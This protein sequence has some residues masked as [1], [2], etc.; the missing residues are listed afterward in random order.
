MPPE[1]NQTIRQAIISA[2]EQKSATAK[3]LSHYIKVSE[4]EIYGHL[5]HIRK[6]KDRNKYTLIV[7]PGKC[8]KC[9]FAFKK[10]ERITKPG[11]C[12]L[13]H[14]ELLEEPVFS[15]RKKLAKKVR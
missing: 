9:G 12:P 3:E 5:D 13:C 11:R 10:R 15:I 1:R 8:R 4:K 6:S 2:L 14:G 7:A